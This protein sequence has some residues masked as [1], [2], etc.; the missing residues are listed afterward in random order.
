MA[1]KVYRYRTYAAFFDGKTSNWYW[2][3]QWRVVVTTRKKFVSVLI[4]LGLTHQNAV[5]TGPC[6]RPNLNTR[7]TKAEAIL[8][9]ITDE[10]YCVSPDIY[11]SPPFEGVTATA[12]IAFNITISP[13]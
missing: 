1:L 8:R 10:R 11:T 6:A 12:D 5:R 9:N 7:G 3:G 13:T 2:E 4:Y